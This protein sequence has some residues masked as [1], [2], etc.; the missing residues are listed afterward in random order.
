MATG[1]II[2]FVIIAIFFF[3]IG[4]K[5]Y[6][7]EKDNIDPLIAKIKGWF[8]KDDDSNEG[9]FVQDNDYQLEFGGKMR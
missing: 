1:D 8:H 7:H 5:V 9:S 3:I 4:S 6:Q 2:G